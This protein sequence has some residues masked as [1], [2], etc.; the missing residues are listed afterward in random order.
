MA[1]I[2][3]KGGRDEYGVDTSLCYSFPIISNKK[4][5][6]TK[7][8]GLEISDFVRA[9]LEANEAELKAERDAVRHLLGNQ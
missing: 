1:V 9:G 7:V 4:G 8:S 6:W 3:S 5:T 2:N